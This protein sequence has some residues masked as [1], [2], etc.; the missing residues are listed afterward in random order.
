MSE[1]SYLELYQV[2]KEAFESGDYRLSIEKLESAAE[3]VNLNSPQGGQVGLWLVTAYQAA[4]LS[5]EAVTLLKKLTDHPSYQIRKQSRQLLYILEAPKLKRPAQWSVV[6]PD[7]S[8]SQDNKDKK[9]TTRTSSIQPQ[10]KKPDKVFV[11]V[12]EDDSFIWFTVIVAILIIATLT[13][14]SLRLI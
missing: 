12:V 7:I 6:I 11:P 3:L 14:E 10:K 8:F 5:A 2:G 13:L 4:N 9:Y 1:V